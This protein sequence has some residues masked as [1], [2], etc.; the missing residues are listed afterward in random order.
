MD[1]FSYSI[2]LTADHKGAVTDVVWE[3]PAYKAGITVGSEIVAI[4]GS[5]YD[6]ENLKDAVTDSKDGTAPIEL[7]VK[8][9]DSYRTLSVNYHGGL[10]Y[11]R[12]ERV[13]GTPALLDDLLTPRD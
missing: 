3:G 13:A 6:A 9:G 10:R 2:G 1:N 8:R 11:P 5:A 12:L 7:L 4:N